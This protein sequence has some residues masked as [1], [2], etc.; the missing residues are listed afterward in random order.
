MHLRFDSRLL[1]MVFYFGLVLAVVVYIVALA[2][3]EFFG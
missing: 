2:T 3:F 1:T